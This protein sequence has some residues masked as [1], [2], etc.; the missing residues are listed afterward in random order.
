MV[1]TN[2]AYNLMGKEG[3]EECYSSRQVSHVTSAGPGDVSWV[4]TNLTI[5]QPNNVL[6]F[7]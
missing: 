2:F 3:G 7:K 6:R 1:H 4:F 5:K